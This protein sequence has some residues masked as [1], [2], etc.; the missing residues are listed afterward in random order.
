MVEIMQLKNPELKNI[1]GKASMNI[2]QYVKL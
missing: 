2:E 1:P